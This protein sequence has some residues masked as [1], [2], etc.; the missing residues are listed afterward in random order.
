[1]VEPAQVVTLSPVK[2]P[3]QLCA[4]ELIVGVGEV[5]VAVGVE[6]AVA[7]VA[8]EGEGVP[9]LAAGPRAGDFRQTRGIRLAFG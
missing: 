6:P 4:R 2:L 1:V 9:E 5:P 3:T 7:P 8:G